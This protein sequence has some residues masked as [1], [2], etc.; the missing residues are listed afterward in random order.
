MRSRRP[1]A[2]PAHYRVH[3][4]HRESAGDPTHR[5]S[6]RPHL[7]LNSPHLILV[8][9]CA[10]RSAQGP[11]CDLMWSDP[12][13]I[14]HWSQSTRGAG[15]LFGSESAKEVSPDFASSLPRL[16]HGIATVLTARRTRRIRSSTTSTGWSSCAART[17][18]SWRGTSSTS[19]VCPRPSFSRRHVVTAI[20]PSAAV[21]AA[22]YCLCRVCIL[23]QILVHIEFSVLC[24]RAT[25][26]LQLSLLFSTTR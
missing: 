10:A 18:W 9:F 7:T 23:V 19:Q 14:L 4:G 3:P 11:Y 16:V 26:S 2:L 1:V 17:S 25:A 13:D 21:F 22:R 6:R 20:L 24:L 12:E 8:L 5:T 15:W